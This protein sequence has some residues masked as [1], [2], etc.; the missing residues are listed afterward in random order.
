M[1]KL[2][3]IQQTTHAPRMALSVVDRLAQALRVG[4][5]FPPLLGDIRCEAVALTAPVARVLDP[6]RVLSAFRNR[7]GYLILDGTWRNPDD[8]ARLY[9]LGAGTYVVRIRGE[10]Y[11]DAEFLLPWP[12]AEGLRR[13]PV[14]QAGN[15]GS[16]ELLPS[17]AYPLPDVTI[18]RLQLGPTILRGAAFA[19]DGTPLPGLLAEIV[20]LPLLAPPELPHL[21]DWPFVRTRTSAAGDWALLLPGRRYI[22]G[23]PE[24]PSRTNL[25]LKKQLTVRIAYPDGP[26]TTLQTVLLGSEHS[27]RNTAMRG[28]V[29]GPGGRPLAGVPIT[30]SVDAHSS[31]TGADGS[32]RLYFDLNQAAVA[33][34]GVTAAP[35]GQAPKTD[36]TASLQPGATVVVPTIHFS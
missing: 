28:Q 18:D 17:S 10:M 16:V 32:W 29:L 21:G 25:P 6:A 14:P 23:A 33:Q 24:I 15:P 7:S 26:V 22:D 27:V 1:S 36:Q 34:V 30:T 31:V 5:A 13:I 20:N 8:P 2:R 4:G 19:A 12:P 3:A 35:P 9:P 11:Q